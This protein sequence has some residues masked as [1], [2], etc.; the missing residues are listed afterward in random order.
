MKNRPKRTQKNRSHNNSS[1]KT[2]A[3]TGTEQMKRVYGNKQIR[4]K[5]IKRTETVSTEKS[6]L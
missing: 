5:N 1:S 4:P 6:T 3:G 2:G